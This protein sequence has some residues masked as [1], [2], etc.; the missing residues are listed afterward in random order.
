MILISER[1]RRIVLDVLGRHVPKLAIM[2]F[3]SRVRGTA[4]KWSDLDLALMAP[5][6]VPPRTMMMIKLDFSDSDL[7]WR[8]DVIDWSQAAPSF[9]QRIAAEMTP[10]DMMFDT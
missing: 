4:K 9:K 3:G 7:P 5:A 10:I 8:V 2:A 1:E 6:P